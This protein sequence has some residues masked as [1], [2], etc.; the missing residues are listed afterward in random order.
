M[1]KRAVTIVILCAFAQLT[2]HTAQA[3]SLVATSA[4]HRAQNLTR[5]TSP[6]A[7][8]RCITKVE[9]IV[10]ASRFIGI[11]FRFGY[12]NFTRNIS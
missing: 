9:S 10:I 7:L 2:K 3:A 11:A 8:F 12:E 4:R 1:R 6:F 5:N